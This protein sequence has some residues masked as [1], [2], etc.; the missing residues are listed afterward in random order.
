PALRTGA[1]PA[2]GAAGLSCCAPPGS[3][4]A[5]AAA[6]ALRTGARA[7]RGRFSGRLPTVVPVTAVPRQREWRPRS[8][9]WAAFPQRRG[10]GLRPGA[11]AARGR[12]R[13][14]GERSPLCRLWVL[15]G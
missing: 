8:R 6:P 3:D 13:P 14:V 15:V 12:W 5:L 4:T 9:G 2:W 10:P 7:G 1:A 11:G